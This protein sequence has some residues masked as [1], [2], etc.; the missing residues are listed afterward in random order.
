MQDHQCPLQQRDH[1]AIRK[2][3]S[4]Q[5]T[6]LRT[7]TEDSCIAVSSTVLRYQVH[8][9]YCEQIIVWVA[10]EEA[11]RSKISCV[12]FVRQLPKLMRSAHHDQYEQRRE[13]SSLSGCYSKYIRVRADGYCRRK[14]VCLSSHRESTGNQ[15]KDLKLGCSTHC[16]STFI[17]ESTVPRRS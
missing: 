6:E 14:E 3:S 12:P 9:L 7:G 16:P 11:Q 2:R 13:S 17:P 4:R 8:V 5:Y 10:V 1:N 15:S